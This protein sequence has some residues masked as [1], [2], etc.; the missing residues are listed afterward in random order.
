MHFTKRALEGLP[1]RMKR[2]YWYDTEVRGLALAVHPSGAKTFYLYRSYMGR[3]R[4]ILIGAFPDVSL[5][6]ARGRAEE[7]NGIIAK[8][9]DPAPRREPTHGEMTL[10]QLFDLY[11]EKYAAARNAES[12]RRENARLFKRYFEPWAERRISEVGRREVVNLHQEVGKAHPYA[13]NH[14]LALLRSLYNRARFD[15]EIPCKNP[16]ER[17]R[18]FREHSR[19]RFLQPDEAPALFKAVVNEK[20]ADMRDYILLSL[21]TGARQGNILGMR[22]QDVNLDRGV[23]TIPRTKSGEA[24]EV[25]LSPEAVAILQMRLHRREKTRQEAHR[26][27]T[28]GRSMPGYHPDPGVFVF[29]GRYGRGQLAGVR[30]LWAEILKRAKI[31]DL[32]L[33]DL[34]RTLGS[35]QAMLGSSL[36]T[37]GASLGHRDLHATQIYARL[38]LD[39]VRKSVESAV[40]AIARAGGFKVLPAAED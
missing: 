23:W 29:P 33:H 17:V 25:A 21:F 39:P 27:I 15:W 30:K 35:W 31:G 36:L 2:A 20:N 24:L 40:A 32:R 16:A 1:V 9:E 10:R 6:R 12:T 5:E 38:N 8:K 13:A 37:I 34:R 3:P 11:Q 18:K 4:R 14:A 7:L 26:A 22:W 19:K 28:E